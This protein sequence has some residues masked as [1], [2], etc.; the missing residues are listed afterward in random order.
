MEE[1]DMLHAYYRIGGVPRGS[2]ARYFS[3]KSG[4][5][6]SCALSGHQNLQS[7]SIGHPRPG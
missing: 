7:W 5:I 6:G 4:L 2:Y 1:L 3:S